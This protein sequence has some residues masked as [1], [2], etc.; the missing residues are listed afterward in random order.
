MAQGPSFQDFFSLMDN[1]ER[2]KWIGF[3]FQTNM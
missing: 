2:I 1:A 3:V